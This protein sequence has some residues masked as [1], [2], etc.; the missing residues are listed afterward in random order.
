MNK[1]VTILAK[2]HLQ[3]YGKDMKKITTAMVAASAG[4]SRATVSRVLNNSPEVFPETSERVLA[5]ARSLG[6]RFPPHGKRRSIGVL[7]YRNAFI[8]SYLAMALSALRSEISRRGYRAELMSS[9]DLELLNERA[10]SGVINLSHDRDINDRW[11]GLSPLPMVNFYLPSRH[12]DNIY[13]I[14]TD[15]NAA[16]KLMIDYLGNFGHRKIGYLSDLSFEEEQFRT[17]GSYA[18]FCRIMRDCG[19]PEPE[20]YFAG[21]EPGGLLPGIRRVCASGVTAVIVLNEF[22]GPTATRMIRELGYRIPA[23]LSVITHEAV[24]VSQ[25]LSPPHTTCLQN[26]PEMAEKG[27]DLLEELIRG[28]RPPGDLPVSVSLIER[29]SV[30]YR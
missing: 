22:Y 12:N 4:V 6:Y 23:D 26:Y 18:A 9:D 1:N 10:L 24:E 2:P 5:A 11:A 3:R 17:T 28:Q 8:C 21:A 13:S 20:Q 25:Y 16:F 19:E 7:L 14:Y 30:G 27:L 15:G 29:E